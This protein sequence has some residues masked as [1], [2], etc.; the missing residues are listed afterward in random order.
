MYFSVCTEQVISIFKNF[1]FL[2]KKEEQIYCY[3]IALKR[4]CFVVKIM[5]DSNTNRE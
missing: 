5:I 1:V 4:N 2:D 3:E